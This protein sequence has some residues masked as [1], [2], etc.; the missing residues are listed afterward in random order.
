MAKESIS[1]RDAPKFE[2][3]DTAG[4]PDGMGT[5]D[6]GSRPHLGSEPR[7]GTNVEKL[8]RDDD[9]PPSA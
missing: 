1:S 3:P 8:I 6:Q 7:S 9:A 2:F 4:Y 5:L